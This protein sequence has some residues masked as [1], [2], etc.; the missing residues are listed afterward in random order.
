MLMPN[1]FIRLGSDITDNYYEY[2]TSL[3]YTPNNARSPLEIW[4]E[5]SLDVEE[6]VKAKSKRDKLGNSLMQT[7]YHYADF[8]DNDQKIFVKG[9]PSLGNIT[10]ITLGVRNKICY[11]Q[12]YCSLGQ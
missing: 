4:N 9:R 10:S 3:K 5:I 8:G 7:R 12:K 1:S 2:E 6:F 11:W